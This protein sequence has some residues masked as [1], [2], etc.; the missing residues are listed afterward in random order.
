MSYASIYINYGMKTLN[1]SNVADQVWLRKAGAG[2]GDLAKIS[3]AECGEKVGLSRSGVQAVE[4]KAVAKLRIAALPLLDA[5]GESGRAEQLRKVMNLP[6]GEYVRMPIVRPTSHK[7]R[8]PQNAYQEIR[9]WRKM[10]AYFEKI[11]DS[12]TA[13]AIRREVS[14][15]ISFVTPNGVSL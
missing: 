11:G 8:L 7:Y 5:E 13:D 9:R 12:E 14:A 1:L 3:L 6:S 15:L 2:V 4:A 10:A